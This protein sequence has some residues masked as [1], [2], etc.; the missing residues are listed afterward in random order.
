MAAALLE[1]EHSLAYVFRTSDSLADRFH[2]VHEEPAVCRYFLPA[3]F[4]V[5]KVKMQALRVAPEMPAVLAVP[6]LAY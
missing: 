1:P 2:H 3:L 4:N 6:N 5:I